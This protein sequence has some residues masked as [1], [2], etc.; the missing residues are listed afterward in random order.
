M[1][2]HLYQLRVLHEKIEL[3]DKIVSLSGFIGSPS[4]AALPDVDKRLLAEQLVVMRRYSALL[5]ERIGRWN[6]HE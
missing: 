3:D 6:S 4:H 1:I 2:E 5:A